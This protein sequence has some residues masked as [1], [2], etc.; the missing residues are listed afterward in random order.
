MIKMV[1]KIDFGTK[2]HYF[3][4][5]TDSKELRYDVNNSFGIR[6]W[7]KKKFF[8]K[9]RPKKIKTNHENSL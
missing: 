3:L 6:F 8:Q 2:R 4:E 7:D 9:N 5:K 1:C